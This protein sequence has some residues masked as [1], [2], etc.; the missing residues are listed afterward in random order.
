MKKIILLMVC[1]L[2]A[3]GC[4]QQP[5]LDDNKNLDSD[6]GVTPD[7]NN[8]LNNN[9]DDST[10]PNQKIIMGI[11]PLRNPTDM[12]DRFGATEAYLR[13]KTGLDIEL[14]FYPTEGELGGYTQ[15]V[16]DITSGAIGLAY[17]A[18]VTIVQAH[19]VNE[20]VVPFACAQKKGSP[21]YQGDLVVL[22]DSEYQTIEDLEG[23][24]VTGTS[25]SSTSGNLFPSAML[26]EKGIDK[27]TFFD[28]GMQYLGSHDKAIEAVIAGTM[29]AAFINEA[30]FNKYNTEGQFRSI[31]KH[32]SVAEFPFVV[33]TEVVDE[34]TLNTIKDALFVMHETHLDALNTITSGYEKWVAISW[35]DYSAAKEAC[36]FV[37]GEALYDLDNWG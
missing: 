10:T 12:L 2:L 36:D 35:D 27:E 4:S 7:N 1:L 22:A 34:Q 20:N 25:K 19:G 18:P 3:F 9:N 37:H 11:L 29:D 17:L 8:N 23:K 26:I 13:D 30:T 24:K 5:A 15:V 31:W 6:S 32:D 16:K 21:T 33:N 14:K 28:G